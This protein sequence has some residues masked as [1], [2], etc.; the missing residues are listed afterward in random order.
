MSVVCSG[1]PDFLFVLRRADLLWLPRV[2]SGSGALMMFAIGQQ[3]L[4][5]GSTRNVVCEL[6]LHGP[7]LSLYGPRS[8][9]A[10]ELQN[11]PFPHTSTW[12]AQPH[13][14]GPAKRC[15]SSGLGSMAISPGE[16]FPTPLVTQMGSPHTLK[17]PHFP[18]SHTVV[19]GL[20]LFSVILVLISYFS[21]TVDRQYCI[22]F[23]C[24]AERVGICCIP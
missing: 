20:F 1:R 16:P 24:A 6:S 21:M 22:G 18:E 7:A 15:H 10:L 11:A 14:C 13:P 19:P 8:S 9:S 4:S 5:D 3:G 2:M 12:H 23:R 17:A